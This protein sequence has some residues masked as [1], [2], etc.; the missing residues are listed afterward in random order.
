[1]RL[2]QPCRHLVPLMRRPSVVER[3]VWCQVT[4]LGRRISGIKHMLLLY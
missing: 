4:T 1:M 2:P 3:G